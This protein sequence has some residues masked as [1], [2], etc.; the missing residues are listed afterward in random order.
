MLADLA[1]S[2]ITD[3]LP[4]LEDFALSVFGHLVI[5]VNWPIL[6]E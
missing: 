3:E 1:L 6:D 5:L 2:E 4:G